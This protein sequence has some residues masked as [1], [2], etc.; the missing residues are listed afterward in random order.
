MNF[1]FSS[2]FWGPF[3][4]LIAVFI[5][6]N[7]FDNFID[8]SI[9]SVVVAIFSL[10]C[11]AYCITRFRFALLPFPLAFLYI[12]FQAPLGLPEIQTRY[13]VLASLFAYIGLS[14]MIPRKRWKKKYK[15]IYA[16]K[17]QQQTGTGNTNED[18]NPS[19]K[20]NFGSVSRHLHADSLET[21]ELSCNFGA[22][23]ISLDK[24]EISP[25]GAVININCSFGSI[26]L[27]APKHWK[28]ND[29]L[30]CSLGNID[31]GKCFANPEENAPHLTLVGNVS[32]GSVE[33]RH[34]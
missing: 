4:L 17:H 11:I 19:V 5:I 13:L 25:D 6:I 14:F 29:Q 2:F 32:F 24:A 31:I 10:L 12:V 33:V 34:I 8:I 22:M 23:E 1:K 16:N 28:I 27:F 26:E 30:N 7:Q 21:A 18:N 20:V 3:L 9:G 15:F